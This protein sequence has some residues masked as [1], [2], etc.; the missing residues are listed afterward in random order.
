MYRD[1]QF[2][3]NILFRISIAIINISAITVQDETEEEHSILHSFL[4]SVYCMSVSKDWKDSEQNNSY[5]LWT[6]LS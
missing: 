5:S 2:L 6:V 3:I 4:K 1:N